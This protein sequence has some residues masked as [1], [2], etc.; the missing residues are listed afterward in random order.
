MRSQNLASRVLPFLNAKCALSEKPNKQPRYKQ[1]SDWV[2]Q[3]SAEFDLLIIVTKLA[4]LWQRPCLCCSCSKTDEVESCSFAHCLLYCSLAF[5]RVSKQ[6]TLYG[7][8]PSPTPNKPTDCPMALP[9]AGSPTAST[10]ALPKASLTLSDSVSPTA[11]LPPQNRLQN[12]L[13]IQF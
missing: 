12:L 4:W 13:P 3:W 10:M 5:V 9:T 1:R 2:S 11:S 7:I 8:T 6:N